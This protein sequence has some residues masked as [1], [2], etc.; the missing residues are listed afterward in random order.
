M[1]RFS[2]IMSQLIQFF[3][4]ALY[5]LALTA[6]KATMIHCIYLTIPI[7]LNREFGEILSFPQ[8]PNAT[9]FLTLTAELLQQQNL[10]S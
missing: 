8:G 2:T 4:L 6:Y 3:Q 7:G 9:R 10:R 5:T 1:I